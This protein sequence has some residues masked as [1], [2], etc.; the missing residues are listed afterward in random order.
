M[1]PH[2]PQYSRGSFPVR[3]DDQI[4]ETMDVSYVAAVSPEEEAAIRSQR[5]APRKARREAS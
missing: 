4:W 5:A 2:Q 3:F 1:M